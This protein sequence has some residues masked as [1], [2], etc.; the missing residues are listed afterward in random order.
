M[1]KM[2]VYLMLR[3][4]ENTKP[5]DIILVSRKADAEKLIKDGFFD[6]FEIIEVLSA[7]DINDFYQ[8]HF[9]AR[10]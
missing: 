6:F 9:I 1:I 4:D 3:V 5:E 7:M 2:K 8:K 10:G